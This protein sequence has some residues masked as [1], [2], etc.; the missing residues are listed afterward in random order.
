MVT[1][2][3]PGFNAHHFFGVHRIHH[4]NVIGKHRALAGNF[5][6]AEAVQRRK[7]IWPQLDARAN[8]TDLMRLFQ[9]HHFDPQAGQ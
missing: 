1:K 8:L 6:D 2:G 5:A 4:G 7:R 3:L 9:Q